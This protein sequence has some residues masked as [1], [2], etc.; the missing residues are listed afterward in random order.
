[1]CGYRGEN[2]RGWLTPNTLSDLVR[3]RGQP[4]KSV[5]PE[6]VG[7]SR[8]KGKVKIGMGVWKTVEREGCIYP[9]F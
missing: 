2:G 6:S 3:G 8:Q 5:M 9:H 4:D 7:V 1:M